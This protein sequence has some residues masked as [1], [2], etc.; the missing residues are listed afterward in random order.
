MDWKRAKWGP[1]ARR[2]IRMADWTS[3][4]FPT[5]CSSVSRAQC[6]DLERRFGRRVR[7]I[8][9]GVSPAE[10]VPPQ[11]ILGLGLQPD[12]FL[13]FLSR[14]VPEKGLHLLIE[15][16]E[17]LRPELPLVVAGAG[18]HSGG[19]EAAMRAHA[20]ESIRFLGFVSGRLRQELLCHASLVVQPSEI[21]GLSNTVLEAMSYGRAVLAS[22][23]PENLEAIGDC[24]YR[25]AA[26]S[27]T[28]LESA[29]RDLLAR[30]DNLRQTGLR[31]RERV[32]REF[33]WDRAADLFERALLDACSCLP[34]APVT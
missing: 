28:A 2:L 32:L 6:E 11:L 16:H 34:K 27:S 14:L 7:L 19:Y 4:R 5:L 3:V 21:E 29:L 18:T 9:N 20:S 31:A 30:P 8:P 17:R 15:A 1:L 12:R 25:F 26:G 24:G 22:D 33:T 10:P 23:I 13:L